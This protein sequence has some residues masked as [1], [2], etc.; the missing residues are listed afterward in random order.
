VTVGGAVQAPVFRVGDDGAQWRA[1]ARQAPAP[2]AEVVGRNMIVTTPSENV[3]TL[4]DP[5]AVADAWDRVL[6]AS[7]ELAG[8]PQARERPERFVADQ[9]LSAGYMHSGYPL[10][11]HL[12][13]AAHLVDAV[14]L[15]TEGNWGFFH[16]VG[17]NHQ[18]DLWTFD[19]T[20]EVTVNLFTLY[21]YEQAAGIPPLANDRGSVEFVRSELA[22]YDFTHPD[23][24]QWQSDPFLALAMYVQLQHAFGWGAYE[25]VFAEYRDLPP[26]DRPTTD[27][28]KRDQWLVRFSR[29]VGMNLGPF[30]Q[31]WGVPTSDAARAS[32]ADLPVWLPRDFPPGYDLEPTAT[33]EPTATASPTA[34]QSPSATAPPTITVTPP[35]RPGS[36]Y[37]PVAFGGAP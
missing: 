34:T 11:C 17:H 32:V 30:F 1:E 15:T 24:A 25:R 33:P 28:E 9:Q 8:Q 31:A 27:D 5:A 7:A 37:L 22:K 3:R 10:M 20:V 16:E 13:Q 23:F 4:D 19:G 26:G 6:D 2:W 18:S 21:A 12:D 14:H 36:A 35:F 29:V